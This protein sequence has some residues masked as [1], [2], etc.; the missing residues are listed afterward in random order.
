MTKK[1]REFNEI[2]D[3]TAM[4]VIVGSVKDC[5]GAVGVIHS[6]W[7][8]LPGRFKDFIAMPKFNMYQSLHTTVIGPEGLPL[9]IQIRT[10]E[11]H[12]M[13]EFGVAAHWIYKQ[14]KAKSP[15]AADGDEKLRWLRQMMDWQQEFRDPT[16]F[17]ENLKVD[18]FEDEVFVF[19]PKGE[20]KSLAAG[21]TP[22]D[23]A[24]EVHTEIGHRCVGAR[25]NGKIV[26]LHYELQSGDIVEILTSKKERGPS[27]D[28]ISMVKTTRA[29]NKI[30]QWF[31]AENREDTEHTGRALLQE[32]LSKRGLPAQKISGS[33]LLADVIREMGFRK[34]DDFYIALGGAKISPKVVVNKILQRLKEG[35]AAEDTRTAVEDLV[36]TRRDRRQPTRSANQYGIRVEGVDDVMLRMAKCCHPV[37]GDPI[38]GY[39]S[40]GRGI[41]I[42]R[43]D[44]PNVATLRKDPERFVRV[45]W[46][47]EHETAF[48]VEV[49]VD[50]YDRT[51]LLEDLSRTFAESG[52][53]IVEAR[54]VVS[55]ADG[56]EPVRPRGR[57]HA[58][59]QEHDHAPAEHRLG[60]RRLPG[61][62]DRLSCAP[63]AGD[64]PSKWGYLPHKKGDC[65]HAPGA[66]GEEACPMLRSTDIPLLYV[67]CDIPD[68]ATLVE[69][70]RERVAT[71][72]RNRDETREARAAARTAALKR[73]LPRL[74]PLPTFRPRFA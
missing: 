36:S 19:T 15:A 54:C 29:R 21:A 37:P 22:L 55:P 71:E 53:N 52:I 2:Y 70:R 16:E 69:W 17:M 31:K 51:R 64:T 10:R 47:G 24:Y 43:E 7:K 4:R 1:G 27:R 13:A 62:P 48:K 59:A 46:E 26:P 33:P 58:G 20:V 65:P 44:C 74:G 5:Y 9:E 18:L 63:G 30:R 25:V 3:L 41:T 60:L 11:M 8:P 34:A 72:R 66:V 61:H 38:A 6:L 73:R 32:N 42:H 35:E 57:R 68:G 56:Q 67:D 12:D 28:W 45:S 23:F 39:I 14:G 40:L 49:E 50:A